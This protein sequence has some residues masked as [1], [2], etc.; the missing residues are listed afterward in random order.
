MTPPQSSTPT[1]CCG[2][3]HPSNLLVLLQENGMMSHLQAFKGSW[4][5]GFFVIH[6]F[7]TVSFQMQPALALNSGH[8]RQ[9]TETWPSDFFLRREFWQCVSAGRFQQP[10]NGIIKHLYTMIAFKMPLLLYSA[11]TALIISHMYLLNHCH[12]QFFSSLNKNNRN[13]FSFFF[14]FGD[15]GVKVL[16]RHFLLCAVPERARPSFVLAIIEIP[17]I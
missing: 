9:R 13:F 3:S 12:V 14:L 2:C 16:I 8:T 1:S 4:H 10:V 7:D 17:L 15:G 11:I 5:S 6:I